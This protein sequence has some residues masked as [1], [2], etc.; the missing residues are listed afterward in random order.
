MVEA[1]HLDKALG[2]LM[3]GLVKMSSIV[4]VP[5]DETKPQLGTRLRSIAKTAAGGRQRPSD[6]PQLHGIAMDPVAQIHHSAGGSNSSC[7]L[8]YVVR[9]TYI[10]QAG[11]AIAV[12]LSQCR[13]MLLQVIVV[14]PCDASNR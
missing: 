6:G 4:S 12:S 10:I 14:P 8:F 2:A 9:N 3:D 11:C 1:G 13:S 7:R 5:H